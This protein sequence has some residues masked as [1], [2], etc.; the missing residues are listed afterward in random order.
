MFELQKRYGILTLQTFSY[1]Q[2]FPKDRTHLKA[3][4]GSVWVLDTFHTILI[5]HMIYVYLVTNFGD[6][7]ALQ[8]NTWSFNLHVMTT[9]RSVINYIFQKDVNGILLLQVTR[10]LHF[11]SI[12]HPPMLEARQKQTQ[13]RDF[14]F[15]IIRG[16]GSN[17]NTA[18]GL[19]CTA[20]TF[21]LTEYT[22][23]L[24][25]TWAV[26]TWLGSA[27]LCDILVSAAIVRSL[28][29]SRTGFPRTNNLIMKLI[30][31]TV[32]TGILTSLW[33][34]L[35]IALFSAS[36]DTLIHDFFNVMLAKLY[37]NTLLATLNNRRSSDDDQSNV[38]S[39]ALSGVTGGRSYPPRQTDTQL[40]GVHVFTHTVQDTTSDTPRQASQDLRPTSS[41]LDDKRP[42]WTNDG[43]L[44]T[45]KISLVL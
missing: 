34:I 13:H 32:N 37:A 8:R 45:D 6:Y 5:T 10:G 41:S 43:D 26:D 14:R 25:Y 2:R 42:N 24:K 16:A 15:N 27:A 7:Q 44:N 18:F 4:V 36:Q 31:W 23:F 21:T 29:R 22:Q 17:R 33:A 35:D 30:L 28:W 40:T 11:P 12:F 39:I 38:Q 19:T 20:L 3:I 1:Y 9:V